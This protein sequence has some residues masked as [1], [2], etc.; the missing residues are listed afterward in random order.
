MRWFLSLLAVLLL[1]PGWAGEARLPVLSSDATVRARWL[2]P[3]GGW[4]R[5]LGPLE[6]LGALSLSSDDHAFGGYSA[7][8]LRGD[9]AVLLS[10]GGQ[11][12]R[13]SIAG[14]R[15][16]RRGVVSLKDG[17]GTGW[18]RQDRDTESLVLDRTT[19]D[20]WIGFERVNE[21]WRF[22]PDLEHATARIAPKPMR[23][24][25]DN[26][27]PESLVRLNDGRFLVL[28]E[29]WR[30]MREPHEALLFAGD[31]TAPGAV[32]GVLHY[33]P[34][35]GFAPSDA[36]V[37]PNGDVLVLNRR[38]HFPPLRFDSVLVRIARDS[39]RPG[40]LLVG[41]IVA[42][43]SA[44]M[45]HENAEG[46]AVSVERGATMIWVVTDND[47][48]RWRPTVLAKFRWHG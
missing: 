20:A 6:P 15:L 12:L 24:W 11:F 48:S 7:L 16:T 1:V 31:P 42:D 46:V 45:A 13:L 26:T 36:A 33:Q 25:G 17:P 2:P 39:I 8:A 14:A 41:P 28:Q 40:A 30:G 35:E 29:G 5:R 43:L 47:M 10:D 18:M 22:A 27:G 9:E 34:P 37:L 4:P 21:I 38:W 44:I 23:R 19:G 3:R 32:W